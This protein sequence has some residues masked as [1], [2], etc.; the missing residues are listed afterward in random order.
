MQLLHQS[1]VSGGT[2]SIWTPWSVQND[3]NLEDVEIRIKA[4]S[5]LPNKQACSLN[6]F[7]DHLCFQG[8]LCISLVVY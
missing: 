5:D 1:L 7:E 4:Y 8:S 2:T 6:I 3:E